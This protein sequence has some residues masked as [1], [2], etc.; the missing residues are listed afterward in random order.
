MRR[1]TFC[2]S[3]ASGFALRRLAQ[4]SDIPRPMP[5]FEMV[6]PGGKFQLSQYRGKVI[7]LEFILTTCPHC[8]ASCRSMEKLYREYGPKGFQMA[9]AAINEALPLS[10]VP[11]FVREFN[12]SFPVGSSTDTAAKQFM[13]YP[14]MLRMLMPQVAFIDRKGMIRAQYAGDTPFFAGDSEANAR[15]QIEELLNEGKLGGP[16]KRT[17]PVKKKTT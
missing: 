13:Q 17:D 14:A 1:S 7:A 11:Q 6:I 8:Q 10:L 4:A 15:K 16:P 2:L 5:E 3:L 9:A 12:L